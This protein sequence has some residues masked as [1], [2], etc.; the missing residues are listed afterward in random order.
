MKKMLDKTER[1]QIRKKAKNMNARSCCLTTTVYRVWFDNVG[2]A[3]NF[4]P[5]RHS[6][7]IQSK[8]LN[9]TECHFTNIEEGNLLKKNIDKAMKFIEYLTEFDYNLSKKEV[10]QK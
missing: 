10:K 3:F 6:V 8:W 2:V 7:L 4:Y 9:N 5:L 1:D